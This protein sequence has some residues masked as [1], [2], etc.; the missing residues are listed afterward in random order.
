MKHLVILSML[1]LS[2]ITANS[3]TNCKATTIK[4]EPC[5]SKTVL[6]DGNCVFHSNISIRCG[7]NTKAN[8]LCRVIVKN[9]GEKCRFHTTK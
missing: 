7:A 2:V 9:K 1:L 3:Q 5:K 8:K 4:N 6:A